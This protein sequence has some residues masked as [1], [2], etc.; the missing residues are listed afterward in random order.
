[1]HVSFTVY[2]ETIKIKSLDKLNARWLYS[3]ILINDNCIR[4]TIKS[5]DI[6][7]FIQDSVV[8]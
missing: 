8:W 1:M 6:G 7:K 4:V 2:Q 3:V 5:K